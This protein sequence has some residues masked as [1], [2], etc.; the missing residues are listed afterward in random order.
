MAISGLVFSNDANRLYSS[1]F[2][3][4]AIIWDVNS[5]KALKRFH[6]QRGFMTSIAISSDNL[7]F[8][9]AR[10]KSIAVRMSNGRLIR[11]LM[12]HSDAVNCVKISKNIF[13]SASDNGEVFIWSM[14]SYRRL[15]TFRFRVSGIDTLSVSKN[16]QCALAG[17]VDGKIRVIDLKKMKLLKT[18]TAHESYIY[19]SAFLGKKLFISASDEGKAYIW[20]L[21][22]FKRVGSLDNIGSGVLSLIKGKNS[23]FLGTKKAEILE[24]SIS[25]YRLIKRY[26]IGKSGISALALRGNKLACGN[27]KGRIFIVDTLSGN[28]VKSF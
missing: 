10:D 17:C 24:Y 18:I 15:K 4:S 19:A 26:S 13:I 1:S 5:G 21:D 27:E 22:G 16:G 11:K 20:S 6:D 28:I 12:A 3:S 2:D 14:R 8:T 9:T 7:V 23:I 25:G